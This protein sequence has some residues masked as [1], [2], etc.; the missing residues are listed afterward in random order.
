MTLDNYGSFWTFDH[1]LPLSIPN[2]LDEKQ[3]K[4]R[5]SW[6]KYCVRLKKANASR[7]NKVKF[8]YCFL[9][10]PS[11]K[12]RGSWSHFC[13]QINIFH[14]FQFFHCQYLW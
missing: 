3:V 11:E 10:C 9:R 7:G 13:L 2:L 1:T 5:F 12:V 4:K 14:D 6:I 8:H